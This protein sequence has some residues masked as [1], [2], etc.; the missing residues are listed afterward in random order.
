MIIGLILVILIEIFAP[1][2]AFLF[3]YSASS[4]NLGTIIT[5]TL[6]ILALFLLGVPLGLCSACVFQGM[7][8]GTI[9]LVLTVIRELLLVL[10]FAV[11][12]TFV[13]GLGQYGLYF[14]L[15]LG[16]TL[17]SILGFIVF[18]YYLNR[19]VKFKA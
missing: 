15:I 2:I 13:F 14:G 12:L 6:R 5:E 11:V 1:Q 7:G 19:L 3:S 9:S 8:K 4:A 17:G 10:V 16:V 18:K